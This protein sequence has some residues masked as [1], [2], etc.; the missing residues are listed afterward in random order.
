MGTIWE[1]DSN[2]EV[3]KPLIVKSGAGQFLKVP[4]LTT[5]QR[6]ALVGANGQIVYDTNLASFYHYS[7]GAWSSFEPTGVVNNEQCCFD[8]VIMY[9]A[10]SGLT[11]TDTFQGAAVRVTS[12]VQFNRFSFRLSAQGS[13]ALPGVKVLIYQTDNGLPG[14]AT[15]VP[16]LKATMQVNNLPGGAQIL[17]ATPSEGTVTLLPGIAYI[18]HARIGNGPSFYTF[19]TP[20]LLMLTSSVPTG[21]NWICPAFTTAINVASTP[22]TFDPRQVA[23]GGQATQTNDNTALV[24]RARQV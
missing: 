11:G 7:A 18:L 19:T 22:A 15:N 17:E 1:V 23:D 14:T 24:N 9:S 16:K 13:G 21:S 12:T 20:N 4:S 6:T 3:A 5:A 8:P 2:G 10:G